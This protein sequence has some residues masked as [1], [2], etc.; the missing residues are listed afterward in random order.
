[1]KV[2]EFNIVRLKVKMQ[3]QEID[4]FKGIC[5]I[6]RMDKIEKSLEHIKQIDLAIEALKEKNLCFATKLELG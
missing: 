4:A 6:E 5:S 2:E 1:M 3:G